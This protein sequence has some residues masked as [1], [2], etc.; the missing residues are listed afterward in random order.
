MGSRHVNMG[1]LRDLGG[2][3]LFV[4]E[5]GI[6]MGREHAVGTRQHSDIGSPLFFVHVSNQA[7]CLCVVVV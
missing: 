4:R 2:A 1:G 6:S 7:F 5:R 3:V